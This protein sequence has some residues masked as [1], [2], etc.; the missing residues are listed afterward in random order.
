MFLVEIASIFLINKR[1]FIVFW[2]NTF[3]ALV[4]HKI[5]NAHMSRAGQSGWLKWRCRTGTAR[6]AMSQAHDGNGHF[7]PATIWC[8]TSR[9]IKWCSYIIPVKNLMG[10]KTDRAKRGN[11]REP[12]AG[13][14]RRNEPVCHGWGAR[15]LTI[16]MQITCH[17][18]L[19]NEFCDK[20]IPPAIQ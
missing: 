3:C 13:S 5:M 7:Y 1:I 14:G 18:K 12:K 10:H 2:K 6:G 11:R 9:L 16:P 15:R 8:D 20:K 19:F 17:L 4:R